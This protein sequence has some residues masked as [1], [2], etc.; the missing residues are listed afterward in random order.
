MPIGSLKTLL[1]R[2]EPAL[3]GWSSLA[4]PVVHEI[5]LRSFDALILDGQHGLQDM[6]DLREGCT[7][8]ALLGKPSIVRVAPGDLALAGRMADLGASAVI[9]PMV[10]SAS[11]AEAF[12]KALRYMPGGTRSFGPTRA[13]DLFGLTPR[14]YFA[15]ADEAVLSFAMIE[16]AGAIADLDAILAVPELGGV[17]LGP[18]DLSIAIGN[19]ALDP[20]GTATDAAVADVTRRARAA[21]KA[22]AI[23][24]LDA[25]D[26]R[27]YAG[28]GCQLIGISSDVA[29]LKAGC[30]RLNTEF[31]R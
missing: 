15:A 6:A 8:A 16:T 5:L 18:S 28:M 14:D 25:D 26:A 22:V 7:R 17:F 30:E 27:R 1:D 4:N 21:G 11:E 19:G 13:A 10:D 2:P 9:L 31:R 29:I 24:A 23:Y 20:K 3:C 12:A